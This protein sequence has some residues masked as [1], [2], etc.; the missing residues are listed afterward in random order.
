MER[1]PPIGSLVMP[2]SARRTVLIDQACEMLGVSK[3]TVYYWIRAGRLETVRT[4]GGSQ[5]VL[6]SSIASLHRRRPAVHPL[7]VASREVV[8]HL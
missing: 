1:Y 2:P 3:R 4:I 6:V 5:R 8:I 7:A